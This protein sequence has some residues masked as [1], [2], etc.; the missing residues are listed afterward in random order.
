MANVNWGNWK[1][2]DLTKYPFFI[3]SA[4]ES[5]ASVPEEWLQDPRMKKENQ[6]LMDLF[7]AELAGQN[8]EYFDSENDS[9]PPIPDELKSYC[10]IEDQ[11]TEWWPHEIGNTKEYP[12]D[13]DKWFFLNHNSFYHT[14]VSGYRNRKLGEG[15][16][17]IV[18]EGLSPILIR[19]VEVKND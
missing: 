9:P 6:I 3:S 18:F 15:W 7:S 13:W 11:A 2:V 14:I 8:L 10:P 17:L 19:P 5:L 12:Y 4:D 1:K 16:Y